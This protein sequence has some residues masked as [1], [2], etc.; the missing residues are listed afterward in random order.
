MTTAEGQANWDADYH[1]HIPATPS[2]RRLQLTGCMGFVWVNA[3]SFFHCVA[4]PFHSFV[5]TTHRHYWRATRSPSIVAP[6]AHMSKHIK[7]SELSLSECQPLACSWSRGMTR[8]LPRCFLCL[9]KP[10]S[11]FRCEWHASPPCGQYHGPR[12]R[13][14]AAGGLRCGFLDRLV[15]A[16]PRRCRG[17]VQGPRLQRWR[18]PTFY[19]SVRH[20][21]LENSGEKAA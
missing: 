3:S 20:Q 17:G 18:S 16:E 5:T 21:E 7:T 11:R 19:R 2:H 4:S 9:V 12:V 10:L 1:V 14:R 13:V 6:N 8:P 15:R